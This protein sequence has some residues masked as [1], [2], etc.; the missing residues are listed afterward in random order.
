MKKL[1]YFFPV[2]AI[3]FLAC[4]PATGS[5]AALKIEPSTVQFDTVP[6]G[7]TDKKIFTLNNSGVKSSE[8]VVSKIEITKNK[9]FYKIETNLELPIK[10]KKGESKEIEVSYTASETEKDSIDGLIEVTSN[11]Y[12]SKI[13]NV[14]LKANKSNARIQLSK[15]KIEFD[16]GNNDTEAIQELTI[17][18]VGS[19]VLKF[20]AK[21]NDSG[22]IYEGKD[23]IRFGNGTSL[24]FEILDKE[25][26]R[27]LN[28]YT[29]DDNNQ[30]VY[31]SFKIRIKYIPTEDG[32]DTGNLLIYSNS[33]TETRKVVPISAKS[34]SCLLKIEPTD[35]YINFGSRPVGLTG[36]STI[37]M[38]NNGLG[39]CNISSI[40]LLDKSDKEFEINP[41]TDHDFSQ[42]P[43]K[44][45]HL[46]RLD[47]E[48]RFTPTEE[49]NDAAGEVEIVS[50][51]KTWEE[52]KKTIILNGKKKKNEDPVCIIK[53]LDGSDPI[54][55]I[56]PGQ[57]EAVNCK[58]NGL[59]VPVCS[60]VQMKS[61][62]YDPRE[63]VQN[64]Y[65]LIHKWRVIEAPAAYS[66]PDWITPLTPDTGRPSHSKMDFYIPYATSGGSRYLIELT[67]KNSD[68]AESTCNAEVF[69]LTKNSLHVE[70]FWDNAS[71]VDLH[72]LNPRRAHQNLVSIDNL[73]QNHSDDPNMINFRDTSNADWWVHSTNPPHYDC[74][75][76]NCKNGVEWGTP[77]DTS[78]NPG[79]DRDDITG[80]GPENI[81]ISKPQQGWYRVSIHYYR[82]EG[83]GTD[84]H[85]RVYC[86]GTVA[87][88]N[89]AFLSDTDNTWM[90]GDIYWMKNPDGSTMCYIFGDGRIYDKRQGE[91]TPGN[92]GN[93]IEDIEPNE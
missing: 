33:V 40:K 65:N 50:D 84:A 59:N 34:K 27:D 62:S 25:N 80:T 91:G 82:V 51:D 29:V 30:E 92:I 20:S 4:D 11:D 60:N 41:R 10:L 88:Q 31:D 78:D 39:D 19:S 81:N 32:N 42:S 71:D 13:K 45:A 7:K 58:K 53:A 21:D 5:D 43:F 52:G 69:G 49:T 61:E 55:E 86:N 68:G 22:Q 85:V 15:Q 8:L 38:T 93:L 16:T 18:N 67:V 17:R 47:V 36:T 3:L 79:L 89:T 54:F 63:G 56:E 35:N 12:T 72:V 76:R 77:G 57:R 24:A 48:V 74:H 46:Q 87:Y 64:K 28:P 6:I 75:W 23:A 90:V 26:I 1:Y 70:L 66:N 2:L 14:F 83:N 44:L 73:P 37:I 9:E